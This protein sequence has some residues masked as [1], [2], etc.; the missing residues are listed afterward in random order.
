MKPRRRGLTPKQA[1]VAL[2]VARGETLFAASKLV[3]MGLRTVEKWSAMPEFKETVYEM[4]REFWQQAIGKLA[5][6]ARESVSLLDSIVRNSHVSISERRQAAKVILDTAHSLLRW[7]ELEKLRQEVD[8]LKAVI[9]RAEAV[10]VTN[11]QLAETVP[12]L[13]N[14]QQERDEQSIQEEEKR[15][16]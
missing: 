12:A 4:R 10:G 8:T 7:Q 15:P 13:N 2:A 14:E 16:F 3:G 1:V 5:D 11:E 6:A 9:G